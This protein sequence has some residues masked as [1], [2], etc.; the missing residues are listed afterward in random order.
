MGCFDAGELDRFW[1]CPICFTGDSLVV[2]SICPKVWN[3]ALRTHFK[4]KIMSSTSQAVVLHMSAS[5]ILR[6]GGQL[7]FPLYSCVCVRACAHAR[8]CMLEF[9]ICIVVFRA[10]P[11]DLHEDKALAMV[12]LFSG[13]KP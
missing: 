10:Q 7:H 1:Q 3:L 11:C 9:I 5:N 8:T 4:T 13:L 12:E 6:S 2:A